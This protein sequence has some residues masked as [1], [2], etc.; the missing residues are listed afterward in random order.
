MAIL[1]NLGEKK[2]SSATGSAK[3]ANAGQQ[4]GKVAAAK[5]YPKILY[6]DDD[7][8]MVKL[9]KI[10]LRA[11]PGLDEL[12]VA[13][14]GEAAL[15]QLRTFRPDLIICDYMMPVMD[16]P[17]F[18]EA[19]KKD[20]KLKSIPFFFMTGKADEREALMKAGADKVISKPFAPKNLPALILDTEE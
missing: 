5:T 19:V 14:N 20:D 3:T 6:V 12:V 17:A 2:A 11:L 4:A 9:V 7:S 13:E 1:E 15:R 8:D 10:A 18:F 16:G